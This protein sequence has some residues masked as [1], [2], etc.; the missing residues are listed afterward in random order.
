MIP[1]KHP[2]RESAETQFDSAR[3]ASRQSTARVRMNVS[4]SNTRAESG[5]GQGQGRERGRGRGREQEQGQ[6]RGRER[7]MRGGERAFPDEDE[8]EI[9]DDPVTVPEPIHENYFEPPGADDDWCF[10]CSRRYDDAI[11]KN[12][13]YQK[14]CNLFNETKHTSLHTLYR[15][16]QSFYNA[17]FRPYQANREWTE[18]S[19]ARH[20]NEHMAL[21]P[22]SRIEE[23]IRTVTLQ[24]DLCAAQHTRFR[25]VG[26][27]KVE[28][29]PKGTMVLLKL[30]EHMLRL[31]Q[32]LKQCES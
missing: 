10:L 11:T 4:N 23:M 30:Q 9:E 18:R 27:D 3:G 19:I 21:T 16:I 15:R 22:R 5:R 8:D 25:V 12:P 14:L 2:P 1:Q 31:I 24:M 13:L 28:M 20:R 17:Y 26:T 32:G 6:G 29:D 7:D